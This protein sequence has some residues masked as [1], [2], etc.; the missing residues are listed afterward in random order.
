MTAT[1]VEKPSIDVRVIPRPERHPRIFGM[2]NSLRDGEAMLLTVDHDPVP[3]HHHLQ[4]QFPGLFGWQ[5][6][7]RGPEIWRVEIE[8]LKQDGCGCGCGGSH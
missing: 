6:L 3:L 7:E 4:N 1:T 5:Y 8:R 2:L